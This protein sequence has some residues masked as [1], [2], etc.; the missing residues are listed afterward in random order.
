MH[1]AFAL[2]IGWSLARLVERRILRRVWWAYPLVVTFVIVATANHFVL[3]A[4]LGASSPACRRSARGRSDA[5]AHRLGLPSAAA[6]RDV[7]SAVSSRREQ[8]RNLLIESR[9]TR[10]RSR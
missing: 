6:G 5:P 8:A 9:L 2:M 3:D 10:T 7:V 1:V 4:V